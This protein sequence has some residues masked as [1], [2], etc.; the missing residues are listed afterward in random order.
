MAARFGGEEFTLVLPE[1]NMQA[2]LQI[3]EHIQ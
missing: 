2:A 3:A 1:T